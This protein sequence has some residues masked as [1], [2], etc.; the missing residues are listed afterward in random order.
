MEPSPRLLAEPCTM[1]SAWAVVSRHQ[2]EEISEEHDGDVLVLGLAVHGE[3][4][5]VDDLDQLQDLPVHVLIGPRAP[6]RRLG[7]LLQ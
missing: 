2:P 7:A 5:H 6:L 1:I 4:A 3:P